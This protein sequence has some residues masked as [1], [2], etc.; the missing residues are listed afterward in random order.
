MYGY[1]LYDYD[2]N[3]HRYTSMTRSGFRGTGDDDRDVEAVE[4]ALMEHLDQ[5]ETFFK[6]PFMPDASAGGWVQL[7]GTN[8]DV[9]IF[10]REI[11]DKIEQ[12]IML[13][14]DLGLGL[15]LTFAAVIFIIF[16][17]TGGSVFCAVSVMFFVGFSMMWG[18]V[19]YHLIFRLAWFDSFIF[20]NMFSSQEPE[21]K[22][23]TRQKRRPALS[24]FH[25]Q[26]YASDRINLKRGKTAKNDF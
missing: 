22:F 19:G 3:T 9:R 1:F 13:G 17:F 26:L 23:T 25:T 7:P 5:I 2:K 14:R 12:E 10:D 4:Q 6:P 15:P 16:I 24:S 21:L 11:Q 18:F 20:L 8:L